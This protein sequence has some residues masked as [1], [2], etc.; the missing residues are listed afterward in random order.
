MNHEVHKPNAGLLIPSLFCG[1]LQSI[2]KMFRAE[3]HLEYV[4][5]KDIW[6]DRPDWKL[7]E[8]IPT[9]FSFH[10]KSHALDGVLWIKN[11]TRRN[12]ILLWEL[13]MAHSIV[14]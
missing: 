2:V 8:V 10:S 14:V 12:L 6:T 5:E 13:E 11:E 9:N 7:S 3:R 1:A 4:Y